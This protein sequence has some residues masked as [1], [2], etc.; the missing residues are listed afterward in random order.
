[1]TYCLAPEAVVAINRRHVEESN[2]PHGVLYPDR[3]RGALARPLLGFG[4]V[5]PY[6][7]PVAQAGALL[8]GVAQAHAFMQGNKRTAWSVTTTYLGLHGYALEASN[9][10]A[11]D[12]VLQTVAGEYTPEAIALWMADRIVLV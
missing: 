9:D 8:D 10:E 4:G 5:Y 12:L 3:L 11:V 6:E 2:E 7:T 1:M